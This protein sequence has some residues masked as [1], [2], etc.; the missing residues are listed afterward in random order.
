ML[1]QERY[2]YKD[3]HGFDFKGKKRLL[4]ENRF[5]KHVTTR[6]DVKME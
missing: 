3:I 6:S 5:E 1:H 4:F 2:M